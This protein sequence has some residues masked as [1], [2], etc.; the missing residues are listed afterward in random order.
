MEFQHPD[1]RRFLIDSIPSRFYHL[2]PSEFE[3]FMSHLFRLDGYEVESVSR[4]G[5][6][7]AT[8]M[9]RKENS[10]MVIRLLRF[11]PDYPAG[12]DEIQ[13]TIAA[14]TFCEADQ[15]WIITTSFFSPDAIREAENADVEYWDWDALY[16]VLCD[17]FFEGQSHLQYADTSLEKINQ[18]RPD[19][20]LKLK[21][22]WKAEEGIEAE[23]YNLDLTI[24]NP[25]KNNIYIHLDLPAVIDSKRNQITAD[26]WADN[27]F[28]AGMLYE[29]ASVRT[30]ALFKAS[31]M[32]ERP[33]GGRVMLTCHERTDPPSTYHLSAKLKGEACYIVTYCYTRKS[34]E[35]HRMIRFR[36]HYLANH[37]AGRI[38]IRFYY[39]TAPL[40]IKLAQKNKIIDRYLR[41]MAKSIIQ[42]ILKIIPA[43]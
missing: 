22:K 24:S 28:I 41:A 16:Q 11:P 2:T 33:P 30:N 27:E 9:A 26:R 20:E 15:A 7:A 13:K 18:V 19:P 12:V 42:R 38:F 14:R 6:L 29:G 37:F 4:K 31:R 34:P 3:S 39:V 32:G 21:V 1:I 40:M 5:D 8:L 10:E 36:D 43:K 23:W 35:Y 17:T 25:T